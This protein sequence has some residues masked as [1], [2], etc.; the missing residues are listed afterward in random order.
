[1][2]PPAAVI[3]DLG[4]VLIDW[5]PRYLYR[6]LFGG[7]DAAMERFLAEVCTADWNARLDAGLPW[8]EAIASLSLA[9]PTQRDM[10]VAFRDRWTEMLGGAYE[11]TVDIL[12][13]LRA[14]GIPLYALTNWSAETFPLARPR[15]PF[16]DWFEGIVVSGAEGIRKPDPR[17]FHLLLERYGLRAESTAFVDDVEENVEVA[18]ALGMATVRFRDAPGLRQDLSRLGLPID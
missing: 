3:F 9:H 4:G 11:A 7:D 15:F 12:A 14:A 5:N 13:D 8:D 10:I 16:L 18:A 6:G 17:I 2:S 1:M